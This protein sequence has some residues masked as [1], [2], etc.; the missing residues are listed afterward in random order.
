MGRGEGWGSDPQSQPLVPP[1][2]CNW[3]PHLVRLIILYPV[4]SWCVI[5]SLGSNNEWEGMGVEGLDPPVPTSGSPMDC[6]RGT[7][8]S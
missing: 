5:Y 2:D 3:V 4:S 1:M 6:N 7:P 8:A